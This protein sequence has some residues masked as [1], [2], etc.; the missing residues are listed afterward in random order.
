VSGHPDIAGHADLILVQH[1]HQHIVT[2]GYDNREGVFDLHRALSGMLQEHLARRV[3]LALH[4]SGTLTTALVWHVPA[5]A[6]LVRRACEEGLLELIGSA[7]AQNVMPLFSREHNLRQLSETLRLYQ[8]HYGVHPEYV[9]CA[10]VPERVWNT[11][12]LGEVFTSPDLPNGGYQTVFLDDRHAYRP[13][14]G[15]L[16]RAAFDAESAP[17]AACR[18]EYAWAE[19]PL[20]GGDGRHLSPYRIAGAEDL[21]VLPL[22]SELRYALPVHGAAQ[23]ERLERVVANA[24]AL[25]RGTLLTFGDD[26]ERSA[27]VGPWAPSPWHEQSLS[28]YAATLEQLAADPRVRLRLPSEWLAAHQVSTVRPVDPAGF[29]ELVTQQGAGEDYHGFWDAEEWRPY[30]AELQA[31]EELL[32][33]PAPGIPGGGLWDAAWQQLMVSSYETGWQ[34]PDDSGRYRPAPW[35]KATANHVRE[36]R[37]LIAAA[38]RADRADGAMFAQVADLDGEGNEEVVLCNGSMFLV[39]SPRY[40]GRIVLACDLTA[41]GGRVVVGNLA[42]DWNW[43]EQPHQFMGRPRNHPG[44]LADIGAENDRY[45]IV[46][47]RV[48]EGG[49]VLALGNVEPGS[50]LYGL[51]KSLRLSAGEGRLEVSYLLP[52]HCARVGVE[53]ALCP[54]YLHLLR[55]GRGALTSL[56]EEGRSRR[57]YAAGRTAVWVDVDPGQP[58][59][60]DRPVEPECGHAG[61]LRLSAWGSFDLS[62]NA[63]QIGAAHSAIGMSPWRALANAVPLQGSSLVVDDEGD[64][65]MSVAG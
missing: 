30:R 7:Y 2:A 44:G 33:A 20:P 23:A 1:A 65:L 41:P 42:D 28:P 19:R 46:D 32:R 61:L 47:L 5:F 11:E 56:E 58:V 18:G 27:G 10:W 34:E 55:E 16:S 13:G 21:V 43:Q 51:R 25:G 53:F 8:R 40:G 14:D 57:G 6:G 52:E 38:A 17:A 62:F 15:H 54:D 36:A 3:P 60:W 35:A 26:A 9:T 22:S 37:L 48:D 4:I 24:A 29:Y 49:L 31:V 63:C 39:I 50:R 64:S 45:A 12:R 59:T